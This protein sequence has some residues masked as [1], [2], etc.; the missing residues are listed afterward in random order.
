MKSTGLAW[1]WLNKFVK[2]R[3]DRLKT[4]GRKKLPEGRDPEESLIFQSNAFLNLWGQFNS[5]R[6]YVP[7]FYVPC[8][9]P[10]H[11]VFQSSLDQ[12]VISLPSSTATINCIQVTAASFSSGI[13]VLSSL[14]YSFSPCVLPASH[15]LLSLQV[16]LQTTAIQNS[17]QVWGY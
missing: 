13:C 10:A 5:H 15:W 2:W 3:D 1:Y 16:L 17:C 6:N 12:S 4:S 14:P 11:T 7:M 8:T 9:R